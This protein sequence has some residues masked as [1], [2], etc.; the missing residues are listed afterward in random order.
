MSGFTY[1]EILI[2]V[3]LITAS[4]VPAME[5]LSRSTRG[6]SV[7][8][9]QAAEHNALRSAMERLLAE[10]FNLLNDAAVAAGGPT[11][12]TSYSDDAGTEN[13]ALVYLSWYD[14]D[15]ADSDDDGFTGTDANLLW[16]KVAIESS[17]YSLESLS[18]N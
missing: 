10:P 17:S 3:V 2:A 6:L 12:L 1:L 15:N 16:L 11:I 5:S 18:Y 8:E 7:I 9:Q 4:L 14:G 13:R